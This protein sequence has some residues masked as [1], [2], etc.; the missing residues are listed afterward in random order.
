MPTVG[1]PKAGRAISLPSL[2][3]LERIVSHPNKPDKPD[4]IGAPDRMG[5]RR[6]R[7]VIRARFTDRPYA[8]WR[9]RSRAS[10]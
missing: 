2:H 7:I 1:Q 3:P 9:W 5:S 10:R 8:A 6:R 4:K